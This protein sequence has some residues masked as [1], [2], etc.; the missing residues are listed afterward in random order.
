MRKFY[1]INQKN[2]FSINNQLTWKNTN[3][4]V[5]FKENNV[6][7][8]GCTYTSMLVSPLDCIISNTSA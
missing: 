8:K 3:R 7:N 5:K 2:N 6:L 4:K 1:K